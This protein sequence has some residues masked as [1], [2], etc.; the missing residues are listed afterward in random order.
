MKWHILVLRGAALAAAAIVPSLV[1]RG[2]LPPE[3]ESVAA[4]VRDLVVRKP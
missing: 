4:L 3:A 1:R 2:K